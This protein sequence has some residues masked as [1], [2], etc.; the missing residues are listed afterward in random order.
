MRKAPRLFRRLAIIIAVIA[1]IITAWI[2]IVALSPMA[3]VIL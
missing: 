1:A 2:L 3:F